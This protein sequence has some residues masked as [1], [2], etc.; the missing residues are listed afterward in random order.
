MTEERTNINEEIGSQLQK[1]NTAFIS[2]EIDTYSG[3]K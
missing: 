2:K 1:Q 3:T